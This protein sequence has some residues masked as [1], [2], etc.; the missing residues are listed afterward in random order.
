VITAPVAT[1]P[2]APARPS[3]FHHDERLIRM[4]VG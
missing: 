2:T 1:T 4:P 3:S